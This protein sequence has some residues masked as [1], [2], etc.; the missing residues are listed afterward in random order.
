MVKQYIFKDANVDF[1]SYENDG[2]HIHL[3]D[4]KLPKLLYPVGDE[5]RRRESDFYKPK[6]KKFKLPH[7][8]FFC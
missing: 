2:L 4:A 5:M 3:L 8:L 1:F 6:G 7:Q